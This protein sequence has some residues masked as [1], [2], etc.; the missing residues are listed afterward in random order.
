MMKTQDLGA[1]ED[2][3][4]TAYAYLKATKHD[5]AKVVDFFNEMDENRDDRIS[6]REFKTY[7][8]KIS[9]DHGSKYGSDEEFFRKL[10]RGGRDYWEYCDVVTF[11][12]IVNSGRPFCNECRNFIDGSF[13]TC[14]QCFDRH[15]DY[16]YNFCPSCYCIV[17]GK[18]LGHG[19]CHKEFMDPVS[20]LRLKA[21]REQISP[22]A[23]PTLKVCL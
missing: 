10:T 13:F 2:L 22:I 6:L 7:M 20:L 21:K 18:K 16:N 14:V 5:E 9:S 11:L 19:H 1:M 15:G 3:R 17:S 4:H 12:Y 8:T 23:K